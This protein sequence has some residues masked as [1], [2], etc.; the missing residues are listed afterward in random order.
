MINKIPIHTFIA[1]LLCILPFFYKI[2]TFNGNDIAGKI[3]ISIVSF[4]VLSLLVYLSLQDIENQE[5]LFVGVV[6]IIAV[7]SI[8]LGYLTLVEDNI[9]LWSGFSINYKDSI[10][11]ALALT[12][13]FLT[14][15]VLSKERALGQAD[16]FL[17]FIAGFIVGINNILI[18][19]YV[20][21]I[22]ATIYSLAM[23][24]KF[25]KMRDLTIPLVP[26]IVFGIFITTLFSADIKDFVKVF[27]NI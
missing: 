16:I 4:L 13:P 3:I 20:T 14:I 12:I 18:W 23:V 17:A 26:F 5:I 6:V 11:G 22:S 15:V 9:S 25:K 27:T 19:F 2:F 24:I 7:L 1:S 21:I 10:L 8:T